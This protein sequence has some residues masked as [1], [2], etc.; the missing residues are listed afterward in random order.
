LEMQ[1]LCPFLGPVSIS[2]QDAQSTN[3]LS[4]CKHENWASGARRRRPRKPRRRDHF[5]YAVRERLTPSG[6]TGSRS[7][8][9]RAVLPGRPRRHATY[10]YAPHP[11]LCEA[12]TSLRPPLLAPL[13]SRPWRSALAAPAVILHPCHSLLRGGGVWSR[14]RNEMRRRDQDATQEETPCLALC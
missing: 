9:F 8:L 5:L 13:A 11:T 12:I 3:W 7:L 6:G 10:R 4:V 1:R 2:K 14:Y